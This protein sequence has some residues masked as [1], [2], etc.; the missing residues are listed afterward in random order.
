MR[1]CGKRSQRWSTKLSQVEREGHVQARFHIVH[2]V[3]KLKKILPLISV[4]K[5][6]ARQFLRQL[7]QLKAKNISSI[8]VCQ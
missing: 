1:E 4:S 3:L 7:I 2:K 6:E 8:R 5:L